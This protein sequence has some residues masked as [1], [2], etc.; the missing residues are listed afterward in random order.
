M[1]SSLVAIL[2][3]VVDRIYLYGSVAGG[4][5]KLG[6][7]DLDVTLLINGQPEFYAD[8][9]N[10]IKNQLQT[11][12]PEITKVDFDIG[13][14]TE[15]LAPEN[16]LSWGYWLKHLQMR[17]GERCHYQSATFQALASYCIGD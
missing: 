12:H 13:S 8:Q 5:A 7:S 10:F 11:R 6:E 3:E 4:T 1:C 17:L 16:L 15:A 9:I 2:G 14:I